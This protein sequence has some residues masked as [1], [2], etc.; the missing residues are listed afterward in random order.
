MVYSL[1]MNRKPSLIS[2]FSLI[3]IQTI[4]GM[5]IYGAKFSSYVNLDK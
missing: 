2:V 4:W 1:I 3:V 5:K